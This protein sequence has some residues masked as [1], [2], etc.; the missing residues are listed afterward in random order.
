M[1]LYAV[2]FEFLKQKTVFNQKMFHFLKAT[3]KQKWGERERSI[4]FFNL[5]KN[6][7]M[8]LM[9]LIGGGR[10]LSHYNNRCYLSK[11]FQYKTFV[12]KWTK[13][14]LQKYI[15]FN[16]TAIGRAHIFFITTLT[17]WGDY[18]LLIYLP[19]LINPFYTFVGLQVRVCCNP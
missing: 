7:Y 9:P 6:T 1:F 18:Y 11:Y 3:Q 5:I 19:W 13:V 4:S 10:F 8:I 2:S 17:G 15:L 12:K 14:P 16:N